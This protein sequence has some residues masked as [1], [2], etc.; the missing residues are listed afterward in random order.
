[1]FIM[2]KLIFAKPAYVIFFLRISCLL[3]CSFRSNSSHGGSQYKDSSLGQRSRLMASMGRSYDS[4]SEL[5]WWLTKRCLLLVF[6]V[7]AR[8]TGEA[9]SSV[10]SLTRVEYSFC[11]ENCFVFHCY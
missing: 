7:A 11:S 5:A 2:L 4:E 10:V 3:S 9:P 1:M 8:V 6:F